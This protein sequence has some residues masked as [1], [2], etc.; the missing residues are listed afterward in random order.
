MTTVTSWSLA[1]SIANPDNHDCHRK[2][3]TDKTR[4]GVRVAMG[5]LTMWLISDTDR[6]MDCVTK[7]LK[8]LVMLKGLDNPHKLARR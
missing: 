2:Q 7:R 4:Q 3:H 6:E 5:D 1:G 8:N